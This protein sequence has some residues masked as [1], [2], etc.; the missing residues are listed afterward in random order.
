MLKGKNI[1]LG[2]CGSVAFYKAY[3]LLSELKKEGANVK[4]ALS[5]GVLKFTQPLSFEAVSDFAVLYEGGE[6]WQAGINHIAYSKVDLVILAPASANTI[7]SLA[8]GV[9]NTLLL[10]TLLASTAPLL[11]A[12][13]ANDK[14]L[15]HFATKTSFEILKQNGATIVP[16]VRKMLACKDVGE[17]A[18][19]PT[20]AIIYHAKR[21]LSENKFK[22]KKI[23]ITGGATTEAID[24]VRAITNHSSGKMA[25]ALADAFYYAGAEVSLL[26][27]F[28][29]N[30]V[31]YKVDKF[32][33]SAELLSLVK[34][35][36]NDAAALVMC[37]AVSDYIVQNPVKGKIKKDKNNLSLNLTPNDDILEQVCDFACK[38]IG[39]KLE[40]DTKTAEE[41]AKNML[42]KK[43]LDA[44]CLNVLGSENGFGSE[45]NEIKFITKS[46]VL[47]LGKNSKKELAKSIA[48]LTSELLC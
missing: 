26:A 20:W 42:V 31:P 25:R 5:N 40:V 37:A 45:E 33:S 16:P 35:Q 28:E 14:M 36:A 11:I 7:N 22:G 27:S 9:A 44:V 41:N 30:D 12:P 39:F 23:I 18:L 2:V 29:A 17:G 32:K 34:E 19:A 6:D 8:H 10:Q 46:S 24:D 13:A 15:S 21:L 47:N 1:L 38:K 48:E 43:G 3:E 4:I